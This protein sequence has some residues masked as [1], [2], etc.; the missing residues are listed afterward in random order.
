MRR[1]IQLIA[2]TGAVM[3]ALLTARAGAQVVGYGATQ[4]YGYY[5]GVGPYGWGPYS[6]GMGPYGTPPG[7]PSLTVYNQDQDR[8]ARQM[9]QSARYQYQ[10]AQAAYASAST[11]QM[12]RKA[13]STALNARKRSGGAAPKFDV[14]QRTPA[15]APAVAATD[16]ALTERLATVLDPTGQVLWPVPIDDLMTPNAQQGRLA[17]ENAVNDAYESYVA[18]GRASLA[19]VVEARQTLRVFGQPLLDRLGLVGDSVR[20]DRLKGHLNAIDAALLDMGNPEVGPE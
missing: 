12:R 3:L 1:P 10:S 4:T 6:Y 9:E 19:R 15:G 14:R 16:R 18:D 13:L 11:N 2:G 5:G 8:M 7:M 17:A 20:Y